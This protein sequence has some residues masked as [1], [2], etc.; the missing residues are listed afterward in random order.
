MASFEC[1]PLLFYLRTLKV[2]EGSVYNHL[3]N[4]KKNR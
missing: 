4:N 3:D 1:S 2:E